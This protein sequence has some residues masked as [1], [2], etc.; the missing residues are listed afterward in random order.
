MDRCQH[1]ICFHICWEER[2]RHLEGELNEWLK[3]NAGR[4]HTPLFG[5]GTVLASSCPV[6]GSAPPV[7]KLFIQEGLGLSRVDST[8]V[9]SAQN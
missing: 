5:D 8:C 7:D 1:R 6:S 4:I 9:Q 3:E 2:S